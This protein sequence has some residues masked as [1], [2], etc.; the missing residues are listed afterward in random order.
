MMHEVTNDEISQNLL[1]FH[2]PPHTSQFDIPA[3][4]ATHA[5]VS[6]RSETF[7]DSRKHCTEAVRT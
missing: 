3:R 5:W 1:V 2:E 6:K 4:G 7:F